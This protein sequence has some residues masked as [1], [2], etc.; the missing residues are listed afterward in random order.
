MPGLSRFVVVKAALRDGSLALPKRN[1]ARKLCVSRFFLVGFV[2][3]LKLWMTVQS[4]DVFS[5]G[6]SAHYTSTR[7]VAV[8]TVYTV[9]IGTVYRELYEE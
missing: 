7:T 4:S 3:F 9:S 6:H 8:F 1:R 2:M 5:F